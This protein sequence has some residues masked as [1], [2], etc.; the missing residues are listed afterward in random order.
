MSTAGLRIIDTERGR[1]SVNQVVSGG[2]TATISISLKR[3]D[4]DFGNLVLYLPNS[5][6]D[7]RNRRGTSNILFT[8]QLVDATAQSTNRDFTIMQGY[9]GVA[10][11]FAN[12]AHKGYFYSADSVLSDSHFMATTVGAIRIKSAVING[13]SLDIAFENTHPS[14]TPTL[15]VEIEWRCIR[16]VYS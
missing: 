4:F 7:A 6:S 14:N 13:A 1:E 16:A 12:W 3:T 8:R 9:T 2:G 10:Y 5:V 15:Q 11:A